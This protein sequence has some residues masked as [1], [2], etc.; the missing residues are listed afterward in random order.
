[1][2]AEIGETTLKMDLGMFEELI[3]VARKYKVDS[4]SYGQV[5][6]NLGNDFLDMPDP[7]ENPGGAMDEEIRMPGSE[8][9]DYLLTNPTMRG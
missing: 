5:T 9:G 2:K 6:V 4:F 3:K 7:T 1:M 8:T